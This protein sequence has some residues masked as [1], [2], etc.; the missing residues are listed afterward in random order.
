MA[1]TSGKSKDSDEF[2]F[3]DAVKT[4]RSPS[5]ALRMPA[6]SEVIAG[7]L[8]GSHATASADYRTSST[9]PKSVSLT[10]PVML[11]AVLAIIACSW[12]ALS[13]RPGRPVVSLAEFESLQTGMS[14]LDCETI[15]GS[16]GAT[17]L[18]QDAPQGMERSESPFMNDTELIQWVNSDGSSAVATFVNGKLFNKSQLLLR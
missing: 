11:A 6:A 16:K 12:L 17:I 14:R 4:E 1:K 3:D 13:G 9:R 7:D 8:L 15:V 18:L 5:A 10:V 2:W